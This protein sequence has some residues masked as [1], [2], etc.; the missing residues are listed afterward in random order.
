MK[1]SFP[2]LSEEKC[3]ENIQQHGNS[4]RHR[5]TIK[6]FVADDKA[7]KNKGQYQE[8]L[9]NSL[10]EFRQGVPNENIVHGVK[11]DDNRQIDEQ[12]QE[13]DTVRVGIIKPK[14]KK[15][16]QLKC[17]QRRKQQADF[18]NQ[19][20]I[21]MFQP[22]ANRFAIHRMSPLLIKIFYHSRCSL[23]IISCILIPFL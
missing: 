10:S 13:K 22:P 21:Q 16:Y 5:C 23:S 3:R 1:Y 20:K 19:D 11:R 2:P 14:V 4:I 8:G 15:G 17:C 7:Q 6:L 12:D 9:N 18:I